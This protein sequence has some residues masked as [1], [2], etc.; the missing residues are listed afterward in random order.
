MKLHYQI[1]FEHKTYLGDLVMPLV[2]SLP[3]AR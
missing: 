2:I 3:P 1:D